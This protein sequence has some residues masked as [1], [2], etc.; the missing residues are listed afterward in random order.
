MSIKVE[1]KN[2]SNTLTGEI[3]T[4]IYKFYLY[5]KKAQKDKEYTYPEIQNLLCDKIGSPNSSTRGWMP[6]VDR[7][8]IFS[9]RIYE[10]TEAGYYSYHNSAA[11]YRLQ[12]IIAPLGEV[13]L[14]LLE[15]VANLF[16]KN[17]QNGDL[18]NLPPF[19]DVS[20][21]GNLICN[22]NEEL[23]KI[24]QDIIFDI[25]SL[26]FINRKKHLLKPEKEDSYSCIDYLKFCKKYNRIDKYEFLCMEYRKNQGLI[27]YIDD[28]S[29]D[30]SEYRKNDIKLDFEEN[31]FSYIQ[32]FLIECNLIITDAE[33]T[34]YFKLNK[35]RINIIN[36]LIGE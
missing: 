23:I 25:N 4:Y 17:N 10:K 32:K 1:F 11:T 20:Q 27:N 16:K 5:A 13:Y 22:D 36:Y 26:C 6:V 21:F 3:L 12:D 33:H 34:G 19:V 31:G 28:I 7:S 14:L 35:N 2:P 30:I 18:E 29:N 8:G 24:I 9:Y 15:I